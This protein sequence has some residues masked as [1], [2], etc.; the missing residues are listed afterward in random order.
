MILHLLR[1]S[2]VENIKIFINIS[3]V[4]IKNFN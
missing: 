1:V 3:I 2:E 4:H